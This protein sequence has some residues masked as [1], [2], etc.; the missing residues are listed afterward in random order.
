MSR[1]CSLDERPFVS[2]LPVDT[3]RQGASL[4]ASVSRVHFLDEQARNRRVSRS[5]AA[6]VI[7]SLFISGIP[8]SVFISPAL[9]LLAALIAYVADIFATVPSGVWSSLHD[10]AFILPE[11]W[12]A[13][14][15]DDVDIPWLNML[16]LMLVPGTVAICLMWLFVRILFRRVGVGG[17]LRRMG[18]REPSSSPSDTRMVNL[19]DEI[20]VSAGVPAPRV[21][22]IDA[23]EPNAT[24]IGLTM[25]RATIVVSTGL[26]SKLSRDEAQALIAH[27][28]SSVG[29]GDLRIAAAIL[30]ALQT[31]GAVSLLI[32]TPLGPTS[33]RKL[34]GVVRNA[35]GAIRG[36]L[37][38][39][40][41]ESSLDALLDGNIQSDD[42]TA[43]TDIDLIASSDSHPLVQLF[44]TVPLLLTM[45]VASIAARTA[46]MVFT[47]LISGPWIGLLWRSRRRL[48]DAGAVQ[49]TRNPDA[50][51]DALRKLF[52][53]D[54]RIPGATPINFLFPVWDKAVDKDQTRTDISAT[55]LRMHPE[56][57]KR[58]ADVTRLG[59]R[60][61][62][63]LPARSKTSLLEV[64]REVPGFTKMLLTVLLMLSGMIVV[65][66]IAVSCGMMAA[67]WLM[68]VVF[69]KLPGWIRD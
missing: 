1:F 63:E 16:W 12:K 49:L 41:A 4:D 44:V 18:A 30:S 39:E 27:V 6:L 52:T 23:D 13:I 34:G 59:A 64:V 11:T 58:L 35:A 46:T 20:A 5:V 42:F 3:Q 8:L 60:I 24:A 2:W 67:W 25:D 32:D 61:T 55:L 22:I 37:D 62:G 19:V 33:R 10:A 26:V 66:L 9:I 57:S 50:L 31:W 68:K 54:V 51:A 47:L 43:A 15:S 14:R 45:G 7:M 29:N 17:A 69:V 28:M 56:Q 53:T 40:D 38:L 48:A 65:N 21:L 36:K